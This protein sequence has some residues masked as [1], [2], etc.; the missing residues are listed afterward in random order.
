MYRNMI[1]V[2]PREHNLYEE[3]VALDKHVDFAKQMFYLNRL[4]HNILSQ[5][6]NSKG[7]KLRKANKND[8]IYIAY[9]TIMNTIKPRKSLCNNIFSSL[10]YYLDELLFIDVYSLSSFVIEDGEF[11]VEKIYY[12]QGE[13]IKDDDSSHVVSYEIEKTCGLTDK[14]RQVVAVFFELYE[15]LINNIKEYVTDTYDKKLKIRKKVLR[16]IAKISFKHKK[17]SD[18]IKKN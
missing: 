2:N 18:T 12:N 7:Y 10:L 17:A 6:D 9:V 13:W 4:G 3:Y 14:D 1:Y 15:K 8:D 5:I 16:I 11:A